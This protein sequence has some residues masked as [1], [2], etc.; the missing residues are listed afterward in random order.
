VLAD[1]VESVIGAAYLHGGLPLG[2][3]CMKYFDLGLEWKPISTRINQILAGADAL[4]CEQASPITTF[5]P[6][7][8]D[9]ERMLGYTFNRKVLLVEALTHAS[10][11]NDANHSSYERME[12]LGNS[13]LDLIVHDF[14]YRAP[15]K[16]YSPGHIYLRKAAVVNVHL[17]A[18]ICLKTQMMKYAVVPM[19]NP[20]TRLVEETLEEHEIH[21]FNCLLHS[22][23]RVLED[24]I[25]TYSRYKK[26]KSEIG[27]A[28]AEGSTFPWAALTRLQASK[29]FS[30]MI[31]SLIGAVY[32]DS[33]GDVAIVR[34]VMRELGIMQVLERMVEDDVDVLHPLSRVSLWTQKTGR[35]V[36][37]RTERKDRN[38]VCRVFIGGTELEGARVS[39]S[40][41]RGK[42]SEAEIKLKAAE[43]AI[44]ELKLRDVGV[45]YQLLKQKK[46]G[47]KKT[48]G[49]SNW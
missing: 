8:E 23:P 27:C 29:L 48:L 16:N 31:E 25:N 14:L 15:G 4:T 47:S 20:E 22:S 38:A 45:P 6:Q 11:Q 34:G 46:R 21:L 30:D 12:S 41:S 32:L 17:L 7:L 10:Y 24:Q 19:P 44:R 9:V 3:E 2:Y 36:E 1:V 26:M 49:R 40:G 42:V 13:I 35:E 39:I 28:L 33:R 5:P 37:F 18:Y 43:A